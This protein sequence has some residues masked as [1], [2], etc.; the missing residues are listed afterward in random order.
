LT[1]DLSLV[2]L[3][4]QP[5]RPTAGPAPLLLLLHGVGS[6]E[7][8]LFGLAPYLDERLVVVSARA[9]LTLGPSSFGWFP[10]SFTPEGP[11][12]DQAAAEQSRVLLIGFLD[13]LVATYRADPARVYVGGF[14]QG[15]IM[16][17]AVALTRP[18]KVAGVL[19]MSGRLL[20]E[21]L[22]DR[23]PDASLRGLAILLQHGLYDQVL[24]IQ[25]AQ[26]ARAALESLPVDLDYREYPIAHEVSQQSL[27]DAA[28]WLAE[29]LDAPGRQ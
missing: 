5:D 6:N 22:A 25:H 23:A 28:S 24:L 10:I 15:A 4:R 12:H 14:S 16:S 8:D 2:H 20:L 1:A 18:E 26:A 7:Q 27:A 9:P 13:E 19:A 17:L 3:V 29:R 11:V 21:A